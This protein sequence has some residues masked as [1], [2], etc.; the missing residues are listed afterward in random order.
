[1]ITGIIVFLLFYSF[2]GIVSC[3]SIIENILWWNRIKVWH[4]LALLF[5]LPISIVVII[6][7]IVAWSISSVF[8]KIFNALSNMNIDWLD[9][10]IYKWR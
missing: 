4:M 9:N 2:T 7:H 6:L 5:Y 8:A 3:F 1:M 10:T